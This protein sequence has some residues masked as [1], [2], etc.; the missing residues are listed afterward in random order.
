MQKDIYFENIKIAYKSVKSQLLK[1]II[2]A[3]IIAIGI[4]C[5][6]GMLTAVDAMKASLSGQFALLGANTFSIQNRGPNISIGKRGKKQKPYAAI[7]FHQAQEFKNKFSS[8]SGLVSVSFIASGGAQASYKSKETNPNLAVWAAD[9]NYLETGGYELESGRDISESDVKNGGPVALI[10]QEILSS[11]FANKD[12][13]GEIFEIGGNRFRVIGVLAPKGNSMGFGGDKSIFIPISRARSLFSRS[14]QSF[15]LNVMA[16]GPD[17]LDPLVSEATAEMRK[18]RHLNPIQENDFSI[19]KSDSLSQ[20]LIESLGFIQI[21]ALLIAGITLF[22]AAIALMNIMLV[23]VTERTK[24]IGIRK[25]VGAKAKT[26]R[27]QFLTEATFICVLG[28]VCGILF[29]LAIGNS[30]A[31]LMSGT[32]IVPWD[33]MLLSIVIC[34]FVGLLSGLYPA[35]K[36]SR[37]DP[38]DA[39]RYE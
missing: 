10:G 37:L 22:S 21:A 23:S 12:P 39:L 33:W 8:K 15:S 4:S 34:V 2:T 31:M 24:E 26:I 6:V 5:L 20:T 28:G 32:F 35:Y 16:I 30:M 9:E 14:N 18:I 19:T 3:L 29:G 36:A 17:M 13:L 11:L 25:A 38:I 27:L 1:T 7:S